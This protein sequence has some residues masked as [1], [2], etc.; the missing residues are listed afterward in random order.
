[1]AQASFSVTRSAARP[2]FK[3][4][5]SKVAVAA[6]SALAVL[7]ALTPSL[8]QPQEPA[9]RY[10][11]GYRDGYRDGYDDGR[12]DRPF[13]TSRGA[14]PG[15][16]ERWREEY[17]RV[18]GYND[19]VFYR[20]CR[21]SPDPAGV[22][23]GA[24]IGGLLGATISDGRAAPTVA[25]II[26]GGV[27]G[28]ALTRNLDCEDRSYAYRAYHDGLNAGYPNRTYDWRNPRN[29]HHGAFRIGDYYYD[30]YGFRCATYSQSIFVEGRVQEARGHACRQPDGSWVVVN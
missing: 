22:I 19:D 12:A 27:A 28:A 5:R 13:E 25:G 7:L 2:R 24:L 1:M 16:E 18:Y 3:L 6:A 30:R 8:A 4:A 21:Q 10:E 9:G 20:E 23:V 11:E 15:T 14:A 17:N 26:V 29:G